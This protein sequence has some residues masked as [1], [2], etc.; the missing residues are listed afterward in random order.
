MTSIIGGC[1]PYVFVDA[2]HHVE[3]AGVFIVGI[4]T[5]CRPRIS[6]KF[7]IYAALLDTLVFMIQE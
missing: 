4:R 6:V 3:L 5:A 1:F 7:I 2:R